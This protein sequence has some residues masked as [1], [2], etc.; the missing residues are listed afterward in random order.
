MRAHRRYPVTLLPTS[1]VDKPPP[2]QPVWWWG[3]LWIP[4]ALVWVVCVFI[5]DATRVEC[6]S[7]SDDCGVGNC[8]RSV[9]LCPETDGILPRAY[10]C[11]DNQDFVI[12]TADVV[13]ICFGLVSLMILGFTM[14][15][16]RR[17]GKEKEEDEG[18]EE[19]EETDETTRTYDY[20]ATFA[21]LTL[22]VLGIVLLTVS[23]W[24]VDAGSAAKPAM[25]SVA[26]AAFMGAVLTF[27]YCTP[28]HK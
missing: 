11:G 9:C 15:V 7:G 21:S 1:G 27:V 17:R 4:F 6:V 2:P 20:V 13:G 22:L 5:A 10:R 3:M 24:V 25:S 18:E 16:G 26:I 8:T 28:N 19:E 14:F 12:N 23:I